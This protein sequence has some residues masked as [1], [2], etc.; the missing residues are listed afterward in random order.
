[1]QFL[2]KLAD[3]VR[4]DLGAKLGIEPMELR[5]RITAKWCT[6]GTGGGR[7][8]RMNLREGTRRLALLLGALG[9]IVGGFASYMELQSVMD[10]RARHNKFEQLAASDVVKRERASEAVSVLRGLTEDR[11][12]AIL[13]RLS[14]DLKRD[15]LAKL[16]ILTKSPPGPALLPPDAPP[17]SIPYQPMPADSP[18]EPNRGGIK[19]IHWTNDID[20]ESIETEDGQALHPTATRSAWEYL[21]VALLPVFGFLIPWGAVRAIGW[22]GAGFIQSSK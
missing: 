12:K 4:R 11:Q 17:G 8:A 13:A 15:I 1:V 2:E 9:A 14:P 21:L 10:Q 20:V 7:E 5:R 6:T 3:E 22:V 19:A 16:T 18:S